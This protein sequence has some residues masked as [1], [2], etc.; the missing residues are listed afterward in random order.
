MLP[1]GAVDAHD[2]VARRPH[3]AMRRRQD[4]VLGDQRAGADLAVGALDAHDEAAGTVGI[5]G[6]L[7]LDDRLRAGN[8][9]D[10]ASGEGHHPRRETRSVPAQAGRAGK[11][12]RHR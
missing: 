4:E 8:G 11:S 3:H 5:T 9:T 7:A 10:E 12:G 2:P 6:N 1:E